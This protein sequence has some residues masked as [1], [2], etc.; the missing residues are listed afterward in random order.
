MFAGLLTMFLGVLVVVLDCLAPEALKEAFSMTLGEDEDEEPILGTAYVN[1][2]FLE[3]VTGAAQEQ[4]NLRTGSVYLGDHIGRC[5]KLKQLLNYAIQ[6]HFI[7]ARSGKKH[8][9][10]VYFFLSSEHNVGI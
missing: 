5:I 9:V 2:S 10:Q 8:V 3:E 6:R 1:H 7:T 4:V